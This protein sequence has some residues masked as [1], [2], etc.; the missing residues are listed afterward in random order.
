M[1]VEYA[2]TSKQ[3]KLGNQE[4]A[5][6]AWSTAHTSNIILT[7]CKKCL[8]QVHASLCFELTYLTLSIIYTLLCMVVLALTSQQLIKINYDTSLYH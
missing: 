3:H 2:P 7:K 1:V 4:S 6:H 8:K 5:S